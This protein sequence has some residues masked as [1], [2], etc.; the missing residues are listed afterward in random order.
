MKSIRE[1]ITGLPPVS[2]PSTA[3]VL[4]AARTMQDAHVGAILVTIEGSDELVVSTPLILRPYTTPVLASG[5]QVAAI[6]R[7]PRVSL[8]ISWESRCQSG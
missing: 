1:L 8:T 6:G 5:H 2:L 7:S 4:Q 3:S